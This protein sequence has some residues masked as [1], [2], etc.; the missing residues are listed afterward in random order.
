ML[1]IRTQQ[2]EALA[3]DAGERL[4]AILVARIIAHLR[5]DSPEL[6]EGASESAHIERVR[7]CLERA[8]ALGLQFASSM[9][10]FSQLDFLIA[11]GFDSH[12]QVRAA[13]AE[14]PGSADER[15]ES[16]MDHVPGSVWR[17]L[18]TRSTP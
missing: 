5:A 18:R 12:P 11:P 14:G 3:E 1:T 2:L 4:D 13:L 16:L 15:L 6:L 8:R 17:E 10:R 7:G 9:A